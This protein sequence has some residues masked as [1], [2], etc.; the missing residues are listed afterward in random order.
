MG[1]RR[2]A[3][4]HGFIEP[5]YKDISELSNMNPATADYI[6][7]NNRVEII[8]NG[9]RYIASFSSCKHIFEKFGVNEFVI[10]YERY[11]EFSRVNK[12]YNDRFLNGW[13]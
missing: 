9:K 12:H 8:V 13:K 3:N 2:Y 11:R 5:N 1:K 10:L 4:Y 6:L 7:K